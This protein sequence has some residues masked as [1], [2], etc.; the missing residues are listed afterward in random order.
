VLAVIVTERLNLDLWHTHTAMNKGDDGKSK[1]D[2]QETPAH[3]GEPDVN[4]V[5]ACLENALQHHQAGRLEQARAGYQHILQLQPGHPDALHMSGV[6]AYQAGNYREAVARI[7]QAARDMVPNAGVHVNL[8]NALQAQGLLDEATGEFREAITMEPGLAVAWN[9]L[10]NALR[11]Q[12]KTDAAIEALGKALSIDS[13][14]ADAYVNHAIASQGSGDVAGAIECYEKAVELDP[15][16]GPAAH[17]LAALRGEQTDAAPS[18]HVTQLFDGYAAKFDHH[19]VETLGYSMPRLLRAEI[20]NLFGSEVHYSRVI[21]LGCGTGLAGLEFRQLSGRLTG[22]DLSAG[23][24][25]RARDRGIYDELLVGDLVAALEA[26]KQSY[27]LFIC[28]DVFPYVGK[29]DSL[30]S[31]ISSHAASGALFVFSTELHDGEGFVLQQSGRYAH[32]QEYLRKAAASHKFSVLTM[33]TEN[34][35]KQNNEWIA[36]DLV[37]LQFSGQAVQQ[38]VL[39]IGR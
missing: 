34:L 12:G 18:A 36:G 19:L 32:A 35:R 24:I 37:V 15:G 23:M 2:R 30:F 6:L 22:V 1:A 28:A 13:R 16:H 25:S 21:D 20:D 8:G 4:T 26:D 29:V 7:R 31:T 27:D 39:S 9:N 3:G 5:Q 17:M 14:Y 10:G 38:S 11:M 33:R